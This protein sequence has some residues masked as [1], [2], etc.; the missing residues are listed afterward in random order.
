MYLLEN[1][2][3]IL[4]NIVSASDKYIRR[5]PDKYAVRQLHSVVQNHCAG[6][7]LSP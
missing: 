5:L 3:D 6:L 2:K 4:S 7:R 1:M